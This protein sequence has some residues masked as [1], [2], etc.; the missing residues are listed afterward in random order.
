MTE[1][2]QS[3]A[4]SAQ[5][6]IIALAAACLA[7]CSVQSPPELRTSIGTAP[8]S[9]AQ[10]QLIA[11]DSD[12]TQRGQFHQAVSR[13]LQQRGVTLSETA[14]LV[15]DLAMSVSPGPV[16]VFA[17]EA[18]KTDNQ[19]TQIGS[20]RKSR[21]YDSCEAVR[22]EASLALYDRTSGGLMKSG[23]AES[24]MCENGA[25]PYEDLARLLV[26]DLFGS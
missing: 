22:V 7:G 9:I 1:Y 26:D 2:C 18:G 3:R 10:M 15:A 12:Q 23:K 6:A 8:S 11:P 4:P 21:W 24:F 25:P 13:E 5:P 14:G 16:G 17:S 20:T 19:P